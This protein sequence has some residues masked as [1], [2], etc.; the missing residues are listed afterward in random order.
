MKYDLVKFNLNLEFISFITI[1]FFITKCDDINDN[2][3]YNTLESSGNSI[4]DISD[5]L[6]LYLLISSSGNIYKG[7]PFSSTPISITSAGLNSS[8]AAAVCNENYIIASCLNNYLL[9]KININNGKFESL[10]EYSDFSSIVVSNSS[11]CS[12]SIYDNN[13]YIG[14]SQ[15]TSDNK[16][17]NAV[18]KLNIENKED[19]T[20][21][22]TIVTNNSKLFIFPVEYSKT[23]TTRDISCE[24]IVE[25]TSNEHKLLCVYEN[26]DE[27]EK[28]LNFSF[29]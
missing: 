20:N 29:Y 23:S 13:V 26:L 27:S 22:P 18:I 12:L 1:L 10:V 4:L 9:V 16:I 24:A 14:I 6:D 2:F 28:L 21:G 5:Y 7:I 25:S 17:K 11:S 19:S 8:S 3:I 15:P